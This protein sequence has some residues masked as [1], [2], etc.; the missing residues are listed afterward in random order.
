[1]KTLDDRRK[2]AVHAA[3]NG[4]AK[5][6][7]TRGLTD[8]VAADSGHRLVAAVVLAV[9]D[10]IDEAA[11]DAEAAIDA[12]MDDIAEVTFLASMRIAG[13]RAAKSVYPDEMCVTGGVTQ[14]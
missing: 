7:A 1:M 5:Y 4:A 12:G 13:I 10:A 6:I 11:A 14:V 8:R 3:I 9:A 2:L